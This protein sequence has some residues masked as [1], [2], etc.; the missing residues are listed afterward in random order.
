MAKPD[1]R[2]LRTS[3]INPENNLFLIAFKN[4][5]RFYKSGYYQNIENFLKYKGISTKP[6]S[7]LTADDVEMYR[8][9]MWKEGVG[10][11]RTDAIISAISTFKKYLITEKSFPD[12]FLQRIEDLRINDKSLSDKSVIF[13]REQLFEI[14]AFN[15]QHSTFEYVFEVLFQLG[16]DKKD[17]IFCTPHN[18]DKARHAF[19]N[20]K[21][22]IFIKYNNR[23]NDLFSLNCDE[24]ELKKVITNID[25][26]YFQKL[27]NYLREEKNIIIRPK[28]QQIIYSD[29]IKSRDYFIFRCPNEN[30]SQFVENLAQNWVLVRTDFEAD[31][32]LFCNECKGNLL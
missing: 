15:E 21:K 27:T 8:D 3:E 30:C 13:S 31:Y 10:S 23:I 20:E 14:R 24:Q 28:P 18:A 4:N 7:S 25:Y 5:N 1:T 19:I 16:V 12:N 11:K 26:Q 29:I 2:N 22:G 9:D 32:R 6:L 17:L